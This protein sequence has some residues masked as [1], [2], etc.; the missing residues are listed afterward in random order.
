VDDWLNE[1]TKLELRSGSDFALTPQ[2]NEGQMVTRSNLMSLMC[3]VIKSQA[4]RSARILLVRYLSAA[5]ASLPL[6][7]TISGEIV[8]QLD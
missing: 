8:F 4:A 6:A 2:T 7:L 1:A 5:D 3:S